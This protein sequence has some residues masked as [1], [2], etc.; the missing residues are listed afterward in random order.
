MWEVLTIEK[1]GGNVTGIK[2]GELRAVVFA[3][4][5]P[6]EWETGIPTILIHPTEGFLRAQVVKRGDTIFFEQW[7]AEEPWPL[8]EELEAHSDVLMIA[9]T[10][11]P[12]DKKA[13]QPP[14]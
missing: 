13:A 3:E 9:L 6:L 12:S 4:T 11:F 7:P 14:N 8:P 10:C 2:S 5:S 1:R